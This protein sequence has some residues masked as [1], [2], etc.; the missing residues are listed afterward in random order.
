MKKINKHLSILLV[1][2]ILFC[3]NFEYPI[4]VHAASAGEYLPVYLNGSMIVN[5][6]VAS[7]MPDSKVGEK[8]DNGNKY[9][10]DPNGK[11]S[12]NGNA[13]QMSEDVFSYN[14]F[15][16]FGSGTGD[17]AVPIDGFS[18]SGGKSSRRMVN[19]GAENEADSDGT[20]SITF[21]M[22]GD[23]EDE[24]QTYNYYIKF[25]EN[26]TLKTLA[27][28]GNLQFFISGLVVSGHENHSWASDDHCRCQVWV[29][30]NGSEV[31]YGDGGTSKAGH[32]LGTLSTGW[33]NVPSSGGEIHIKVKFSEDGG[34]TGDKVGFCEGLLLFRDKVSPTLSNYTC[35]HKATVN[36]KDNKQLFMKLGVKDTNNPDDYYY[37]ASEYNSN[38]AAKNSR[39]WVDI[40]FNFSKPV[41]IGTPNPNGGL[42][43]AGDAVYQALASH[44]LFTNTAGTGYI[45][46]GEQRGLKLVQSSG[47]VNNYLSSMTYRYTATYGDF[48]GNSPIPNRGG[49]EDNSG[50][51]YGSSLLSKIDAAGFHDAAGNPLTEVSGSK[52]QNIFDRND[53]GYDVIVDAV[54]PT[55][56]RVGNG[57]Y[58]DILT[59]V[60]LNKNDTVDFI[61]SFSEATIAKSGWTDANTYLLL[62]NGGR[63]NFVS[64]SADGKR[65]TF[66]YT[67]PDGNAAEAT[68]LKAIA[69][70]NTA[71]GNPN[72]GNGPITSGSSYSAYS[73]NLDGRTISDY[74]GNIMVERANE[75]PGK[76]TKQINSFTGWAGLAVDNTAPKFEFTY[77]P[78]G[79]GMLTY[80]QNGNSWGQAVTVYTAATD[81]DVSV[82]SYDPDYSS[83]NTARPSKGIYR[84]DNT[85]GNAGSAVGLIFY[86]W[87]RDPQAP[88]TGEN[89]EAIKRYSLTG[90][91]PETVTGRGYANAWKDYTLTMANNY[92][93]I[94]P[95]DEAMTSSGDG[96]WYLHVWTADMTWDSARQLMQY[97]LARAQQYKADGSGKLYTADEMIRIKTEKIEENRKTSGTSYDDAWKAVRADVYKQVYTTQ[98]LYW[99]AKIDASA[100][101]KDSQLQNALVQDAM[102]TD[103]AMVYARAQATLTQAK[104]DDLSVWKPDMFRKDDSNW[105]LDTARILLDN[106]APTADENSF[107]GIAG[108]NTVD[109]SM[110]ATISDANSGI[111]VSSIK[112][113]WV[114]V[115]GEL[116]IDWQSATEINSTDVSGGLDGAEYGKASVSFTAETK[117]LV[118]ESGEYVLYIE[119]KDIA[120]NE[121][122]L[123]SGET[124][125]KVNMNNV[126]TSVFGPEGAETTYKRNISPEITVTGMLISKVEYAVS[127]ST[128]RPAEGYTE[129]APVSTDEDKM[130]YTYSI[131]EITAEDGVW[132]IH[133]LA[134]GITGD[135][136]Y[137]RGTYLVD[138]TKPEIYVNNAGLSSDRI[139]V[140]ARV[141]IYDA[142]SGQGD[143]AYYQVLKTDKS[144]AA[145]D[146]GWIE[147]PVDGE[148]TITGEPVIY[149]VHVKATDKAGNETVCVSKPF[150]IKA[151]SDESM[152]LPSY[153]SQ[154]ITV[155]GGYGIA[156]LLIET[157]NKDGYR[158]SISTDGGNKW[159]NWLPYM[160]M[161]RMKLPEDYTASGKLKVKFRAPDGTV[162]EPKDIITNAMV[163]EPIWATA[164]FDSTF[165]RRT[166][167]ALTLIMTLSE[168]SE[169]KLEGTEEWRTDNFTVNGNGVYSFALKKGATTAAT[170]FTIVV[171]IFDDT[172]PAAYLSYSEIAP[173]NSNVLVTV[174]SNESV[175]VKNI[176]VRFDGDAEDKNAPA[177]MQYS[178]ERNGVAVF[179]VCDE[180][181]NETI[182]NAKITNIDKTA[183]QVKITENYDKYKF[184][185]SMASGVTLTVEKQSDS[186]EDFTIVG[187]NQSYSVE[188]SENG[189][190][191]FVVRDAVGNLSKISRTVENIVSELPNYSV[192]YT[193]AIS[194]SE[195]SKSAPKKEDV[196]ALVSFAENTDGRKLYFGTAPA[197][198]GSNELPKDNLGRYY[199][200]RTYSQ[201]GKAIIVVSD[202][203]GNM[204]RI[205]VTVEG[206]D[207][208]APTIALNAV[209]AVITPNSKRLS[210]LSADEI[211]GLFGGYTVSDNI[212]APDDIK[213]TVTRSDDI[214]RTEDNKGDLGTAGTYTLIY[215]ATDPAGN[216]SRAAQ[217][218]IIIPGD[219]LLVQASGTVLSGAMSNTAIVPSNKITF[220]VDPQ[221]MQAMF[222]GS[223]KQ[224]VSNKAMRYD[225][226]YVSGLYR[227][228]QLKTIASK[229]TEEELVSKNYSV[230]FPKAGWYTIIIRNQERT[231]EYT[232]F[233]VS[234]YKE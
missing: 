90:E 135:A 211:T 31:G 123:N 84:P 166:G 176:K 64:K 128:K 92:Y 5:G 158:Y 38:E 21:G 68:L 119:C 81:G 44:T 168:G 178:F 28:S 115:G 214:I 86:T 73:Y 217:P 200:A 49:I 173:T 221:R 75:D 196:K 232:T 191:S 207:R 83:T 199:T 58:P 48:N 228:G 174:N 190:Y 143:V 216:T 171:D 192:D 87:T 180:A 59:D 152:V 227:E 63:A 193:Y 46:Q 34:A 56:S 12:L 231:R 137:F 219:G 185:D 198:D 141:S 140:K 197:K 127:R 71:Q 209:Q 35:S 182:L 61:V 120:G 160:S 204:E 65:W 6:G 94:L 162:G 234:S 33:R 150:E 165:K 52:G 74:V 78:Y 184:A 10:P 85:T 93:N 42:N 20:Y 54:P 208:T 142:L 157:E 170:V 159:C 117:N 229:L 130:Q 51:S 106:T 186:D 161:I 95:P 37:S 82:A 146:E 114:K 98:F 194:G 30:L 163:N 225:I 36:P 26:P 70:L 167:N 203:L 50:Y 205:P 25:D 112:Y 1:S 230:S 132:Y 107:G 226:Y 154:L 55:Y 124:T 188:A 136:Q 153:T 138:C 181:G 125:V 189:V 103:A 175:Y 177:K 206:I 18:Y 57:V 39:D 126:I 88:D 215:T 183:P 220:A 131:P 60:I 29:N 147:L 195:I 148:I 233:F 187:S 100:S 76:N 79:S 222:Y 144:P 212:Y 22:D 40:K 11:F 118:F 108:N 111:D 24:D 139:S 9:V 4:Y 104:Y 72:G 62:D 23:D 7:D 151:I 13:D 149:Y 19:Y 91:Q 179:T 80:P 3:I 102:Y 113:Q 129:I 16:C 210:E 89:F 32:H 110:I 156:N 109:A 77:M 41:T 99:L 43:S 213:V 67:V 53:G 14:M 8:T 122:I 202:S 145:D 96:A 105:T 169:Y 69:I 133:V 45:G 121:V 47:E 201:N 134:T 97:E 2:A 15:R 155:S 223:E 27:S 218:L 101:N 224:K 116:G 164:E 172:A 66:R 17:N